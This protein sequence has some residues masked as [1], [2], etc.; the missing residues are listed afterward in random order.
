MRLNQKLKTRRSAD[1]LTVNV[2]EAVPRQKFVQIRL[3]NE[4][5]GMNA[6]LTIDQVKDLI[7][8][9]KDKINEKI[10]CQR[11]GIARTHRHYP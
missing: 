5:E 4:L 6:N 7:Q 10:T 9:L 8:T 3:Q 2:G 11:K 1:F